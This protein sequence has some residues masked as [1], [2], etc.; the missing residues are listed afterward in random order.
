MAYRN[1]EDCYKEAARL[2]IDTENL[3]WPELQKAVS[4]AIKLE[5]LGSWKAPE[6][7][8]EEAP[9]PKT[10]RKKKKKNDNQIYNYLGKTIVLS[11]ELSAERYR[12]VKYDEVLGNDY[13]VTERHFDINSDGGVYDTSGGSVDHDN[14]IDQYHDYTTGTYRLKKHGDRK[15]VALSTV[16]KENSGMIFRPGIDYA[17]VVTWQGKSGYLWNHWR[18]PNV[19][20]LLIQSG[21]YN[22]YKHLF[23][24]NNM[25]YAAGKQLVCDPLLVHRVFKEIEEKEKKRRDEDRARRRMLGME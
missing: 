1:K 12:R 14:K 5:E 10:N 24:D 11:P 6:P 4:T 9:K 13:E 8:M 17:T 3:S 16:P 19:K 18:L 7:A 22:E 20:Q 2:G 23:K 21:Y 15:V 25:W